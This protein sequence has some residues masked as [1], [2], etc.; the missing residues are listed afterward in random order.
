MKKNAAKVKRGERK[1]MEK[2]R[3]MSR[4]LVFSSQR[5]NRGIIDVKKIEEENEEKRS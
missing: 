5:N 4:I 3:E 2:K 1:K